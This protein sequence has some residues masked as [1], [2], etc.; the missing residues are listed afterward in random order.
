[1]QVN[2][3]WSKAKRGYLLFQQ[4]FSNGDITSSALSAIVLVLY[5]ISTPLN[6]TIMMN[7]LQNP[8]GFSEL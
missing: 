3:I 4:V 7:K 5:F 1:M 8:F 2:G 6:A